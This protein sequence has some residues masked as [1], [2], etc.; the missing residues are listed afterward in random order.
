MRMAQ[1]QI[2]SSLAWLHRFQV[3][4]NIPMHESISYKDLA[5][6]CD[7]PESQLRS[8]SR[9]VMTSNFL[10]ESEPETVAHN[11]TSRLFI[12]DSGF[13]DWL[14]FMT[15]H[16]I[17]TAFK[18]PEATAVWGKLEKKDKTMTAWNLAQ[19]T[20][21]PFFGWFAE[22]KERSNQFANYMKAVQG[23]YGTSLR[24]LITGYDWAS[25]GEA[26]VVDV[27][28]IKI[29]NLIPTMII[30]SRIWGKLSDD[31]Q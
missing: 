19:G 24:H 22:T 15:E 10:V 13:M 5:A 31:F 16:S 28:A 17:P 12:T 27:S 3:L 23:S 29:S 11:S 20:D 26:T 18:M 9:I 8:M 21:K 1:Y 6:K 7:V 30:L 2:L 25:L 14:G 4:Q